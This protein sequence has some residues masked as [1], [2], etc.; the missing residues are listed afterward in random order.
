MAHHSS[1]LFHLPTLCAS[2]RQI[3]RQPRRPAI[4]RASHAWHTVRIVEILAL[5]VREGKRRPDGRTRQATAGVSAPIPHRC[6]RPRPQ[7]GVA[8]EV[9]E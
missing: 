2:A 8:A 5:C 9:P 7:P 1:R 6:D 3:E 4:R